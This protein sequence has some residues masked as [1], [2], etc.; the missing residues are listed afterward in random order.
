VAVNLAGLQ[1]DDVARGDVLTSPG[2]LEPTLLADVRFRLLKDAG[3]PLEHNAPVTVYTGAAE[4][5]ARVSLLQSDELAPG[6]TGWAQLRL[7]QPL[8]VVRGDFFVV[9]SPNRTLGGGQIVDA[10]AR[11]H[12][13]FQPQVAATL[14]TMARGTPEDL[15]VQ[16]MGVQPP[17]ELGALAEKAGLT[18]GD[19]QTVAAGLVAQNQAFVLGSGGGSSP[20]AARTLLVSAAGWREM[21][22][23]AAS[24]L[25]TYHQQYPLRRGMPLEEL[26]SRLALGQRVFVAVMERL[27]AGEVVAV[28]GNALSTP[29]WHVRFSAQQQAGVDRFLSA[30]AQAPYAPPARAEMV[31]ELGDEVVAALLDQG[32][33]VR[34]RDDVL[35]GAEAYRAMR[36]GVI[37]R[38]RQQGRTTVADV[39]DLF[40][41]SRRYAIAL[42]EH[43]DQEHVTRRDGDDRVL[44][45]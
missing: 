40:D 45:S 39:R 3:G 11:R 29:G 9:R 15:L 20:I 34:V 32:V 8:A 42:L 21:E 16:A 22:R 1:V 19:A 23:Q 31:T 12:K 25:T 37:A 18:M 35:F 28:Q 43:L 27:Q 41:T 13:R 26:K 33:L 7:A 2:W 4:V 5:E 17:Q 30:L 44:W 6:D 24:I 10:H 36:D 14:E 38:I